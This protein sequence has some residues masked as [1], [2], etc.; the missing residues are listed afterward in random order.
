V[1]RTPAHEKRSSAAALIRRPATPASPNRLSENAELFGLILGGYGLYGIILDADLAIVPNVVYQPQFQA[2]ATREYAAAFAERVYAPES[3]VEMAYG[4]LSVD[5]H[6]FLD[7][8]IIATYV[9]VP[10]TRGRVL[11]LTAQ[12]RDGLRRAIFRNSADNGAGKSLRWQLERHLNP[13]LAGPVTRN[14]ILNAPAGLLANDD[15]G[16][17]DILHEYFVPQARLWEFVRAARQIIR[18]H[19]G[20]LLNVTVRD[21]RRDDRSVLAYARADAFGLVMLFVQERTQAAETRMQAMTRALID[22]ATAS[23]GT[24]YLPY[25]PHATLEQLRRG[26]PA[27]DAAMRAKEHHDPDGVFRNTFYATYRTAA[28]SAV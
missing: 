28:R 11:P 19:E 20:N 7:E 25:R 10:Q 9:P 5:P 8:A 15:P 3:T 23:G 26:Y 17:T 18:R 24:F 4:R 6:G 13:R 14:S 2:V 21:V 16:S 12:T 22:A 27:W 1:N